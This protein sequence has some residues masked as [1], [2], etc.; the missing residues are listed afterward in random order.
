MGL[1]NPAHH[2]SILDDYA[3]NAKLYQEYY[4]LYRSLVKVK[5]E[6]DAMITDEAEKQRRIDLLSYQVQEIEDAAL[7]EGE[8]ETLNARRKVLANASTIRERISQCYALLSGDD[9]TP[10]AVDLLGEASNAIDAAAQVDNTLSDAAGQLLDLYYT[11][12]DVSADLIGRLDG[13]DTNDAEL[14]EIE[15]RIDLIYKLKRK[16]GDT[17]YDGVLLQQRMSPLLYT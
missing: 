17:V 10:G 4:V 6:L 3:Q 16:Y 15:Q 9:E 1:L 5:K 14:D 13:Y 8:E 11:A 12:K 2:L 7:T